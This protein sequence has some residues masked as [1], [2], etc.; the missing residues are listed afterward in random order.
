MKRREEKKLKIE[1]EKDRAM[2]YYLGGYSPKMTI[3]DLLNVPF[4]SYAKL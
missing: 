4:D 3:C 1:L 2:M